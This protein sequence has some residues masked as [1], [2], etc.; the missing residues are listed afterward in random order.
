MQLSSS[1]IVFLFRRGYNGEASV[2]SCQI[3]IPHA[4]KFAVGK[5]GLGTWMRC[6][7]VSKR[8]R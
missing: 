6:T 7:V 1:G 2:N 5:Y 4:S 3:V 8:N